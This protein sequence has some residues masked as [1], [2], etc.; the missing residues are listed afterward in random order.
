MV[1]KVWTKWLNWMLH[2]QLF[3]VV[4][5]VRARR[6][7]RWGR[8]KGKIVYD[9]FEWCGEVAG[10]S[11][12]QL[13]SIRSP[14]CHIKTHTAADKPF[15]RTRR[16]QPTL[17]NFLLLLCSIQFVIGSGHTFVSFNDIR[18]SIKEGRERKKFKMQI[19]PVVIW[20]LLKLIN[21][22]FKL[23]FPFFFSSSHD[24]AMKRMKK[25]FFGNVLKSIYYLS[26][27][28]QR[29]RIV[30]YKMYACNWTI[31]GVNMSDNIDT[32]N[33]SLTSSSSC[34]RIMS[35]TDI[36]HFSL[37]GSGMACFTFQ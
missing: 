37:V 36:I 14:A 13:L 28:S 12:A 31:I 21:F 34:A 6:A 16:Q 9:K 15:A 33:V 22:N 8:E 2:E 35:K 18:V 10:H 3:V 19:S 32:H 27:S 1:R 25:V 29:F 20:A 4:G 11:Q 24:S 5:R 26:V 7:V 23:N 17:S 30:E